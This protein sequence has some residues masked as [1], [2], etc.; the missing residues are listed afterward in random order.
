MESNNLEKMHISQRGFL[1][2][3]KTNLTEVNFFRG[4]YVVDVCAFGK[5]RKNMTRDNKAK[6]IGPKKEENWIDDVMERQEH[7]LEAE[8]E[9]LSSV[10]KRIKHK[11]LDEDE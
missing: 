10:P 9:I 4:V 5:R 3:W 8:E 7:D 6:H 1:D 11:Y 2:F